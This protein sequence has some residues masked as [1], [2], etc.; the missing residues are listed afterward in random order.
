M[1]CLVLAVLAVAGEPAA[2]ACDCCSVFSSCNLQSATEKG[3]VAGIAEQYTYFGTPQ[4]DGQKVSGDGEYIEQPR[5]A[6]FC[7]LQFQ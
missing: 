1:H 5:L 6:D 7:G 4:M 2:L 3:F